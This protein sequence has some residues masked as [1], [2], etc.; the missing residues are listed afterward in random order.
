VKVSVREALDNFVAYSQD[1][2]PGPHNREGTIIFLISIL[3]GL[4]ETTGPPPSKWS[5]CG[6]MRI[7]EDEFILEVNFIPAS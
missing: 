5:L 1:I 4:G 7:L 2:T 6:P 3:V